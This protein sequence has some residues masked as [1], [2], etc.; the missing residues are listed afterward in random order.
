MTISSSAILPFVKEGVEV[1]F[2]GTEIDE[3]IKKV[4][5]VIRYSDIIKA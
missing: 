3:R 1:V 4:Y 5:G 2:W